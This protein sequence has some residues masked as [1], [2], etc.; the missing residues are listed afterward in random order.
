M[1][2]TAKRLVLTDLQ[3]KRSIVDTLDKNA[4]SQRFSDM[5]TLLDILINLLTFTTENISHVT[6]KTN[7]V[8]NIIRAARRESRDSGI[9]ALL[10]AQICMI[11][12]QTCT[13][14][15]GIHKVLVHFKR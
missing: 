1:L 13:Q 5:V 6:K 12:F 3:L 2:I 10:K 7:T 9:V 11:S 15:F 8:N 4:H 14:I